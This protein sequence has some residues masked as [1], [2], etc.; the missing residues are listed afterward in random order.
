MAA[1]GRAQHLRSSCFPAEPQKTP[2]STS[3]TSLPLQSAGT[4]G[5]AVPQRRIAYGG[6]ERAVS[7]EGPLWYR[8]ETLW[9]LGERVVGAGS[10]R[11]ARRR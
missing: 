1:R 2:I 9:Q 4:A 10:G 7:V 11:A 6:G 5:G 8:K 3:Q